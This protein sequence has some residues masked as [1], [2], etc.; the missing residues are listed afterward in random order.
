MKR[1]ILIMI[2]VFCFIL[3]GCATPYTSKEINSI[4]HDAREEGYEDGYEYGHEIGYDDGY[5]DGHDVGYE[6]GYE[7]GRDAGYSDAMYECGLVVS[8]DIR[9]A[10]LYD[11]EYHASMIETILESPEDFDINEI[12]EHINAVRGFLESV[13]GFIS[14]YNNGIEL[15]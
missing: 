10:G 12:W 8:S 2:V 3:S 9:D 14:D 11:A 7:D 13:D 5:D 1:F 4:M 15:R 6:D